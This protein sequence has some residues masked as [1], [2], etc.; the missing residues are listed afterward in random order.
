MVRTC[1]HTLPGVSRRLPAAAILRPPHHPSPSSALLPALHPPPSS[2]HL[3]TLFPTPRSRKITGELGAGVGCSP[4]VIV[5]APVPFT[6]AVYPL[7]VTPLACRLCMSLSSSVS[8]YLFYLVD[9][10]H[11]IFYCTQQVQKFYCTHIGASMVGLCRVSN[12]KSL[13]MLDDISCCHNSQGGII[14]ILF[15]L[16]QRQ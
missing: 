16:I 12:G 13:C 11:Q 5:L 4:V 3:P 14:A 7:A 15:A 10:V 9:V 1:E 8:L 6:P 2:A